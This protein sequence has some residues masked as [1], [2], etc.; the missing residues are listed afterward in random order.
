MMIRMNIINILLSCLIAYT[1]QTNMGYGINT[2]EYWVVLLSAVGI[3]INCGFG[4]D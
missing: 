3:G 4:D 1:I 2:F